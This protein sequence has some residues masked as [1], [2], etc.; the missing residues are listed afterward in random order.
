MH[1]TLIFFEL[2][3]IKDD[4]TPKADLKSKKRSPELIVILL[5]PDLKEFTATN[6]RYYFKKK[7]FNC[8]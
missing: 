8:R 7:K 3:N 1:L 4:T 6:W 2:S 5:K